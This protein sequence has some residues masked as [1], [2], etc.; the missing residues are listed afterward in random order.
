MSAANLRLCLDTADTAQWQKWASTGLFY[1]VTTNPLL[2]ERSQVPCTLQSLARLAEKALHLGM[3]EVQLQTWG[4]SVELMVSTG[5]ALAAIAPQVV[6]KVPI[7]SAGTEA[8]AHLI[9][10]GIRVTLTGVY[11]VHQV[12][13]A[14]SL[15]AEY[16][17]PYL[18]RIND[19]GRNGRED[20]AQMQRVLDG[21]KSP[22]RIL[23][24]SIRS[25]EDLSYL[26]AAGLDTF[27]F[28]DAIATQLF[29]VPATIAAAADFER[30]AQAM[31]G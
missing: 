14:A 10:A 23:A 31:S 8:A 27:T 22:T 30:A 1:G 18:G 28:S 29:E 2:L 20:L 5:K 12:L 21:V 9:K 16:T 11:A 7:T 17:A 6:V 19:M 3:Q 15:G 25:V 4:E 13:I 26:A 24:A